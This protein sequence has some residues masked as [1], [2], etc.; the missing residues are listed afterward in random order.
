MTLLYLLF[1]IISRVFTVY[2]DMNGTN[3]YC[4]Y[5]RIGPKLDVF[6]LMGNWMTV[7]TQPKAVNCFML[8]I[9]GIT[10]GD[11]EQYIHKYGN[12][13][14][15]VDWYN[16]YL[17]VDSP[18]GKHVFQGD[19][20]D[21]GVLENI[22]IFESD[23][24]KYTLHE[25]SADQWVLHGPRGAELAV[26]R[27]CAGAATAVFARVPHWPTP[28]QLYAIL[29]RSG[30]NAVTLGRILC[31]PHT[32]HKPKRAVDFFINKALR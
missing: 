22:I 19:G 7:Y 12:F 10:D 17:E 27:D 24:G 25:Q 32:A 11:R 15:A 16:C 9:R 20:S 28:H 8:N 31:E 30:V 14:G 5:Y 26:M 6:D 21:S 2:G 29:H 3:V 1:C 13:S 23:D 18:L 4:P